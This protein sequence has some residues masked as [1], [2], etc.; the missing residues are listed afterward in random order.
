LNEKV[1][2]TWIKIKADWRI[3][4]STRNIF[5]VLEFYFWKGQWFSKE[6]NKSK[7]SFAEELCWKHF[8][9]F[10]FYYKLMNHINNGN[11]QCV[12]KYLEFSRIFLFIFVFLKIWSFLPVSYMFTIVTSGSMVP[13]I[14]IG[15]LLISLPAWRKAQ[16]G[17]IVI[18]KVIFLSIEFICRYSGLF[19]DSGAGNSD[20]S[21]NS[22]AKICWRW[23]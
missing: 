17:D 23:L 13:N 4:S 22:W 20:M 10:I 6:T 11:F 18:V 9:S 8:L 21:P 7:Y 5:D 14:L 19:Q 15:D 2:N 16:L 1:L 3:F 12:W